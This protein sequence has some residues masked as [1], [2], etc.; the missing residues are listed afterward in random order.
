MQG[1][2]SPSPLNSAKVFIAD[3]DNKGAESVAAELNN[4]TGQEHRVAWAHQLDVVDWESQRRAFE[5]ALHVLG[6]RIDYVMPIA[7]IGERPWTPNGQDTTA[8]FIKP[9]LTVID[10]DTIGVLYT[11]SLAIQQFRQQGPS[12]HGFRGKRK[13]Q[14]Q[15]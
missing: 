3:R 1:L 4:K 8:G 2:F 9:E 11:A 10:V 14:F 5:A 12:K 15:P 6:G 13:F 7:G